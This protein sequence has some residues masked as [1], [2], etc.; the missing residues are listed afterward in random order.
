M[1][2]AIP[3]CIAGILAVFVTACSLSS[4]PESELSQQEALLPTWKLVASFDTYDGLWHE[5]DGTGSE[6]IF[7]FD[8]DKRFVQDEIGGCCKQV[9]IWRFA[10]DERELTLHYTDGSNRDLSYEVGELSAGEL[11]LTHMGRHGPVIHRYE[12]K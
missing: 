3:L 7:E 8:K 11:E 10:E 2:Y 12:P 9:G 4:P 5:F 1:K 6:S